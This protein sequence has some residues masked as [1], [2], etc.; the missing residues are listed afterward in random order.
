[1]H[2]VIYIHIHYYI[3]KKTIIFLYYLYIKLATY[4]MLFFKY[5]NIKFSIP[6]E[7]WHNYFISWRFHQVGPQRAHMP[8]FIPLGMCNNFKSEAKKSCLPRRT[9]LNSF[10]G[11]I[12]AKRAKIPTIAALFQHPAKGVSF[13]AQR[14]AELLL[15]VQNLRQ[16]PED[17]THVPALY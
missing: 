6:Q 13:Q 10:R 14:E 16:N 11:L 9:E 7:C 8:V 17:F 4:F 12:L 3:F 15:W 5:M 2:S 1:M